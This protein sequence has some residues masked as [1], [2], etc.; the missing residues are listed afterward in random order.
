MKKSKKILS[1]FLA[2]LMLCGV[3]TGFSVTVSADETTAETGTGTGTAEEDKQINY[4]TDVYE[5]PEAKLATMKRK[6]K[7]GDYELYSDETSGEVA[8]R[9]VTTGQILFT[10]PYDIG[11]SNATDS[12]KYQLLSQIIIKYTDNGKEREFNSYEYASM[13][14]QI[15]VKNIKNG[16]RVEYT[17]GDE[18]TPCPPRHREHP[19]P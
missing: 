16:I 15:T 14:D 18:A 8:V 1:L 5:T 6:L 19:L 2:V 13:R 3:L 7:K 9:N 10:N 11:A 4:L 12:I 17:L